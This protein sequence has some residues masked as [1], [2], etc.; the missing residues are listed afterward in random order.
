MVGN[1]TMA[2]SSSPRA[3]H[4]RAAAVAGTVAALLLAAVP[5]V[6]QEG[7]QEPLVTDRPDATES[8]ETVVPGRFQLE[9]GYTYQRFAD[10]RLHQ[11]G[12][13][14]LR[15]G[16]LD[17][18]EV[19]VGLDSYLHEETL[20]T[21][22]EGLADSSLGVKLKLLDNGGTGSARPDLAVLVSTTLPTGASEVSADAAQPEVRLAT[23]WELPGGVGLGANF[24]YGWAE[25]T[26]RQERFNEL[27]SSVALGYGLTEVVGV[28]VEHFGTYPLED[29]LE[30][31]NFVNG[32]LTF[33]LG[34]DAQLDA[35]VGYGLNGRDDDVF[36]GFG[37]AFRW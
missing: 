12:E 18:L 25:D 20:G 9:S 13:I 21:T 1:G 33:L 16:A 22:A 35:R 26:G 24:L 27:G 4:H 5:V 36:V 6:A 30:D 32:G 7:P 19:R 29:G 8:T 11:V 14:L 37:S 2:S 3:A 31:E 34:P 23:A 15:I 17:R 28:F 10:L